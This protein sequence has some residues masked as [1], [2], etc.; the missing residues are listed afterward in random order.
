MTRFDTS[1]LFWAKEAMDPI[2]N[3][4]PL[5]GKWQLRYKGEDST[6]TAS[7]DIA[8]SGKVSLTFNGDRFGGSGIRELD[9]LT[10]IPELTPLEQQVADILIEEMYPDHRE[11]NYWKHPDPKLLAKA[12]VRKIFNAP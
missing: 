12:I 3:R 6:G 5:P 8:A 9:G 1:G 2:A 4:I 11:E 10:Q 7:I